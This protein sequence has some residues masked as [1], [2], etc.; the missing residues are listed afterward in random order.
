MTFPFLVLAQLSIYKLC[1]IYLVFHLFFFTG[2]SDNATLAVPIG[3][4]RVSTSPFSSRKRLRSCLANID[5]LL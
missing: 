4:F 1:M 5:P 3:Q 2:V